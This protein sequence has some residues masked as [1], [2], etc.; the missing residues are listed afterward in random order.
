[1]DHIKISSSNNYDDNVYFTL[2]NNY[3]L[4]YGEFFGEFTSTIKIHP[5][6]DIDVLKASSK[7]FVERMAV[8]KVIKDLDLKPN[9]FIYKIFTGIHISKMEHKPL[10]TMSKAE[11]REASKQGVKIVY[12]VYKIKCFVKIKISY[13]NERV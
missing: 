4:T 8:E 13:K 1:M 10:T 6:I 11:A 9:T 5:E 3:K 12:G 7:I 2:N